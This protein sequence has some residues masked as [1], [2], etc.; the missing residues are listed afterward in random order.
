MIE[1]FAFWSA[2]LSFCYNGVVKQAQN[3]S[4]CTNSLAN[5]PLYSPLI[6]EQAPEILELL[7]LG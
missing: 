7:Q 4:R 1:S 3:R 5:L 6:H 2:Q